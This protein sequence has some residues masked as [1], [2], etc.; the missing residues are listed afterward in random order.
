MQTKKW[1]SQY[2]DEHEE[3]QEAVLE[4]LAFN[5]KMAELGRL[6]VGV[7]HELNTPLSVIVSAAQMILREKDLSDFVTELV[8]RINQEAQR[9]SHLTRGITGFARQEGD[10][11][12]ETDIGQCI[13]EVVTL[14]KY[15]IQKRSVALRSDIDFS[16]PAMA[17]DSN[18][19][20]Q[21]LINLIM[22]ALQAMKEGG[23]LEVGARIS[24]AAVMI[25]VADSGTGIAAEHLDKIFEPFYTTKSAGEG[26]G[27]GLFV[28]K[29]IVKEMGGSIEV[30]SVE[31]TGTT[32][33]LRF[34]LDLIKEK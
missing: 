10:G 9:L 32:F 12:S 22:N 27:L 25:R 3:S 24:D 33:T 18:R 4:Q 6:S 21:V 11:E 30:A 20:K 2:L 26:T 29:N 23:L 19:L 14:L 17:I 34:P 16:L 8:A 7:I 31:G 1:I 28:T 15:E 5:E 13:T